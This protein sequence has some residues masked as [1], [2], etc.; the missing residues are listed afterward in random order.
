MTRREDHDGHA[1]DHREIRNHH[2]DTTAERHLAASV[3]GQLWRGQ[4]P[5]DQD[6]DTAWRHSASVVYRW[7]TGPV[8]LHIT[9]GPV[10]D[11]DT[12]DIAH[13]HTKEHHVATVLT[14]TQ[15]VTFSVSETDA[16]GNPT[17]ADAIN[18]AL[19]DPTFGTL[20]VAADTMSVEFVPSGT[21][22]TA[23]L[24]GADANDPNV[25]GVEAIQVTGGAATAIV[26]TAGTPT[27]Q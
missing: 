18:W 21:V 15:K 20:N 17:T 23:N 22:G 3:A 27:A 4:T 8:A 7:L 10:V 19:D 6:I 14:D 24:T 11:Q 16:K 13:H 26:I 12:G 5:A 9:P 1:G 2:R 25:S